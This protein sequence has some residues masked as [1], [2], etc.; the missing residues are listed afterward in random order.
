MC[1]PDGG[2][3]KNVIEEIEAELKRISKQEWYDWYE[4]KYRES[5]N[6]DLCFIAK[7]LERIAALVEYVKANEKLLKNQTQIIEI[8]KEGKVHKPDDELQ[9][10]RV[11][12]GLEE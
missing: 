2:L 5:D 6:T 10:A 7:S 12:L 9:A 1:Y 4:G 8:D 11:A 3:M